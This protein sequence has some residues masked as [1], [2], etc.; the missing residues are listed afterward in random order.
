M[1]EIRI[2]ALRHSAFYSPLLL[3][4]AG[5]YLRDEGLAP[6]YAPATPARPAHAGVVSGDFHV[7]QS[8]VAVDFSALERG[9]QPAT[10]HFAQINARDGFFI[11]SREPRADFQW[12]DLIGRRV[13]VDHFFQ[14]LAMLRYALHRLRVPWAQIQV[15]DAGDVAAIERAFR[16]GDG[17]FVHLQGPAAQQLE[18]DGIA[19]VVAAVGDIVGPVAF[20]SLCARRDWLTSDMAR[21][22]MRGY[23]RARE[24][25]VQAS[26]ADVARQIAPLLPGIAPAV[27]LQTVTRYRAL[28]CWEPATEI[29]QE[30]YES[31]L[32]VFLFAGVITH[33]HPYATLI[34][35]PPSSADR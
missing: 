33:R 20:S 17:D 11:C 7:M 6:V 18:H 5:P 16:A 21:A 26:P 23:T 30:S 25:C 9:E 3:A 31:L 22:F 15:V 27:L 1:T 34:A 32:D 19:H 14:P 10:A 35:P 2:T 28:G 8:A 13:L 4:I 12:R 24:Y 29:A